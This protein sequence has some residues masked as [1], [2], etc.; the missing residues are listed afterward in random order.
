MSFVQI[1]SKQIVDGRVDRLVQD[2]SVTREDVQQLVLWLQELSDKV[3]AVPVPVPAV[4]VVPYDDGPVRYMSSDN[5][6]AI[7]NVWEQIR[8]AKSLFDALKQ[9]VT[10]LKIPD[11]STLQA[12]IRRMGQDIG[13]LQLN[14]PVQEVTFKHSHTYIPVSQRWMWAVI[15][16][17]AI[18]EAFHVIA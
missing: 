14:A 2:S 13:V 1:G 17:L 16:L 8:T 5:S 15:G 12:Q 7:A 6:K 4:P 9:D 18:V 3:D 11:V 10:Q